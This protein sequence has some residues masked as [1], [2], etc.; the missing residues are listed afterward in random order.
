MSDT[1]ETLSRETQGRLAEAYMNSLNDEQVS[2]N[3]QP[4]QIWPWVCFAA[5]VAL[6]FAWGLLW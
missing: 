5:L 2:F 6:G 3:K 4:P 1:T